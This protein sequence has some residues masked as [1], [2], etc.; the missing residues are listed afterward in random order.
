MGNTQVRGQT[1]IEIPRARRVDIKLEVVDIPVSDVDR[2]KRFYG[3]LS[4]RL[5][6]DFAAGDQFRVVRFTPPGSPC[7][8]IFGQGITSAVPGPAQGVYLLVS[9]I[10]AAGAELVDRGVDA[11]ELFHHAGKPLPSWAPGQHKVLI[12]LVIPEHHTFTGQTVTCT[13]PRPAK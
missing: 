13:A 5:D 8:I 2:A 1:A 12:E 3:N 7:S 9:D 10:E 4:C 11:S 6:A